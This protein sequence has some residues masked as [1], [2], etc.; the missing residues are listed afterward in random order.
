MKF[1][2]NTFLILSLLFFISHNLTAQST[3]IKL[4]NPSFEDFPRP[5]AVPRGWFDCGGVLFPLETPPDIHAYNTGHFG[6]NKKAFDKDTYISLVC[7]QNDS[8][9]SISQKL[10]TSLQKGSVY[11][12]SLAISKT[13]EYRSAIRGNTHREVNF[14]TPISLRIWGGNGYCDIKELLAQSPLIFNE[15]W[16]EYTF[17]FEPKNE[18]LDFITFE[19]YSEELVNGHVL[20]DNASSIVLIENDSIYKESR[21][22]QKRNLEETQ[23]AMNRSKKQKQLETEI[24]I[25]GTSIKFKNN[26]LTFSG[27]R[28]LKQVG[29][30]FKKMEGQRKL[31]IDFNGLK[32]KKAK[33][34]KEEI[35]NTLLNLGVPRLDFEIRNSLDEDDQ[36][37]WLVDDDNMFIGILKK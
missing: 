19:A 25:R 10:E 37:K 27:L 6:V 15:E 1:W 17:F 36:V 13:N 5:S 23:K 28:K 32:S 7:R 22:I 16:V 30:A 35:V 3:E 20:L 2:I 31:I 12:F 4:T 14:N 11:T 9:E 29:T 33:L 8:Y 34:R 24:T 26:K 21:S 18:D